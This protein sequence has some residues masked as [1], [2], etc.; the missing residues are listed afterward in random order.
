MKT[1]TIINLGDMPLVNNLSNSFDEAINA[2]KYPLKILEYNDKIMRLDTIVHPDE[3]FTNYFYRSSVN[4]PY[5]EHCKNMWCDISRYNPKTI[6]DIGGNDGTLLNTF[7]QNSKNRLYL[8]NIDPSISFIEDNHQKEINYINTYWGDIKINKTFDLIISTN[9]FQ[10]NINYDKFLKGI[11]D[12][13]DGRWI[14]EF[15]YFL[16]TV[17][18]NQFDQIYHEHVYYWLVYPLYKLFKKYNLKI[19]DI[20]YQNIHGGSLRVISS[21]KIEDKENTSVIDSFINQELNYSF[22]TWNTNLQEKIC[23]D[24]YFIHSLQGKTAVFGAAAKGCV[25]MNTVGLSYKNIEYIIDDTK[26]KQNMYSPT[27]GLQIV[28]RSALKNRP[29]NNIIIL[30]HNFKE[31]I[32]RSLRRD[33]FCGK[34]FTMI[35]E[36]NELI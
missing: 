12:H 33:G 29:V 32:F 13:L 20:S 8:Y 6:A 30:S 28:D 2:N 14:L 9:V 23:G 36:I 31:H 11:A 27:T 26:T 16:E 3:L 7:Q 25:Y 1:K 34:I 22:D 5:V 15:P 21:N 35:P 18:T 4:I 19:I 24:K 17:K 10:H